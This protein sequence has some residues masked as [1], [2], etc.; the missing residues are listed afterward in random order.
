MARHVLL[1]DGGIMAKKGARFAE[2]S[3]HPDGFMATTQPGVPI[4]LEIL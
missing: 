1:L 4:K 3:Q 2:I